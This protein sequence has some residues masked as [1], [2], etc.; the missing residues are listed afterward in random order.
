MSELSYLGGL[1]PGVEP[2]AG[3]AVGQRGKTRTSGTPEEEA[4]LA[5]LSR[6]GAILG[7]DDLSLQTGIPAGPL[8][9]VL[10]KLELEGLIARQ[11]DGRYEAIL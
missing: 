9:A 10:M 4:V 3:R 1:P 8:S 5:V 6:G 11:L 2:P 7:P